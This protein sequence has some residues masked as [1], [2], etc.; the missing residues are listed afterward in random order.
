VAAL[1]GLLAR[2]EIQP[3]ERIV[4]LLSGGGFKD[5]HLAETEAQA[6]FEREPVAFDLEA[7]VQAGL[8]I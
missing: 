7:I 2:G 8:S 4:C 6:L 1:A 3:D 5:S